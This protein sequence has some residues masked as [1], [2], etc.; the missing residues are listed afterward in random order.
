MTSQIPKTDDASNASVLAAMGGPEHRRIGIPPLAQGARVAVVGLGLMGAR[1]VTAALR[2]GHTIV[3]L[4]DPSANPHALQL[5][6]DLASLRCDT[7]AELRSDTVDLLVIATTADLHHR[8]A[9]EAFGLGFRRIVIEKPVSQSV[10]EAFDIKLRAQEKGVRVIVNHGRRYCDAYAR[11]RQLKGEMGDIRTVTLRFG[12]GALGCVGTHWIDLANTL[13]DAKATHVFAKETEP[14]ENPRGVRFNDPGASVMIVYENGACAFI[15]T[16]DDVGF[17]GG[18]AISFSKGELTWTDEFGPWTLRRRR[19]GDLD[20]PLSRYGTPLFPSLFS[21]SVT[22]LDPTNL[23]WRHNGE[24]AVLGY[25][26]SA[27][28]DALGDHP[29]ISGIDAAI[30]TMRVY[31]AARVSHVTSSSVCIDN[32]ESASLARRFSIP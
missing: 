16:R 7:L 18:A 11:V 15:D 14:S 22:A 27:M 2:R 20:R 21:P 19:E 28:D 3:G 9:T 24:Q 6:P 5:N 10:D 30:Q 25:A 31:A 12:G 8:L 17:V 1:H 4:V 29:P 26:A 13:I 32:I 23:L